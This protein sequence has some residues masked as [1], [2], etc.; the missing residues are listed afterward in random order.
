MKRKTAVLVSVLAYVAIFTLIFQLAIRT[1]IRVFYLGF[2]LI[3]GLYFIIAGNCFATRLRLSRWCLWACM[4]FIGGPISWILLLICYPHFLMNA[5]ILFFFIP[6]IC[7]L[8]VMWPAVG[9]GIQCVKWYKRRDAVLDDEEEKKPAAVQ[10]KQPP[11]V[12]RKLRELAGFAGI[13]LAILAVVALLVSV[14]Q[15]REIRPAEAYEDGGVHVFYPKKVESRVVKNDSASSRDRRLYPTKTVYFVLYRAD[16]G[17]GYGLYEEAL[18]KSD[19]QQIVREGLPLERRVLCIPSEN[20]YVTTAPEDTAESY[21]V[22]LKR[23]CYILMGVSAGYLVLCGA[24]WA[25]VEL[26]KK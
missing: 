24:V 23:R 13:M 8:D 12:G 26:R 22:G 10:S 14:K 2:P 19:G 3:V 5:G 25:V 17:S 20:T 18:S 1:D 6:T 7:V 4:E 9:L 11:A 21:T 16:D 15:V